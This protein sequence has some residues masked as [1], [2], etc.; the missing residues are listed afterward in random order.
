M[1]RMFKIRS[2]LFHF[3]SHICESSVWMELIR[4]TWPCVCTELISSRCFVCLLDKRVSVFDREVQRPPPEVVEHFPPDPRTRSVA[5]HPVDQLRCWR[6]PSHPAQDPRSRIPRHENFHPAGL[7]FHLCPVI[8]DRSKRFPYFLVRVCDKRL[9]TERS[10]FYYFISIPISIASSTPP[11]SL[12]FLE[13]VAV[14]Q[15]NSILLLLKLGVSRS[16]DKE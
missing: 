8:E 3:I 11:F 7:A 14:S 16:S 15:N 12:F 1:Q 9:S 2:I 5:A 10:T 4:R 13:D 6:R